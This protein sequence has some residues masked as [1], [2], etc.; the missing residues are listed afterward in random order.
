MPDSRDIDPT[1]LPQ[2]IDALPGI[3][4]A[5]RLAERVPTYLVGGVVRDLLLGTEGVDLDIAI[6]GNADALADLPGYRPERDEH[7]L[8]G[9]LE[10]G[11][12]GD[13]R[14]PDADRELPAAGCPAG[15]PAGVDR[16]GPRPPRLHRERDGISARR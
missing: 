10:A 7:F 12:Q 9:K 2:A 14:R 13:R 6:E 8:T 4:A 15:G 5:R 3:D 11:D 16:G 1:A